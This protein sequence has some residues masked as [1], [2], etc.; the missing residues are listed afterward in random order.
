MKIL[1]ARIDGFRLLSGI[2]IDFSTDSKRNI[3][4]VRAAN[5]SGKT[6]MLTA[7]QWG[8]YGDD[9]LPAGYSLRRMDLPEG[10]SA[11]TRV[12]IEYEIGNRTGPQSY[13]LVR[14]MVTQGSIGERP[15]SNVDLYEVKPTGFE[16]ISS[17]NN[18][19]QQH[20]PA[21]LREVFFTDGDRALNFIEG[22]KSEQQQRVRRAIERMMGLSLLEVSID[23]VKQVEGK[24]RGRFN[25]LTGN[26]KTR[27]IKDQLDKIDVDLPELQ[28]ELDKRK[29]AVADLSAKRDRADRELQNALSAGNREEL[30]RDLRDTQKLRQNL[31][32]QL[33]STEIGQSKLFETE[34]LARHLMDK[35]F[36]T[37]GVTL[38]NLRKK[39][40]IPNK[41]V[42]ILEERLEHSDCICGES[43]DASTPGGKRRR[44]RIQSLIQDSQEADAL[45]AKVSDLYFQAR[46]L[47][48]GEPAS[49]K[50][51]YASAF[52]R[53]QDIS[54]L[55]GDVGKKEA[56]I[57]AKLK[58]IPDI[59][60]RQL[61][62][63][64]QIYGRDRDTARQGEIE[65]DKDIKDLKERRSKLESEFRKLSAVESKGRKV[66]REL[67]VATDIS[68]I[69][70]ESL[71]RMRTIEVQAVAA[72]MNEHF[73]S[74]IGADP[75]SSLITGAKIT[76]EFKIEVFGRNGLELDPSI[77]LNGASR[78]A[79]TISFVLALAEV[80]G[81][82]GP[83]VVDTPLGM[84]AGFV[85]NEVV[86]IACKNSSQLILFLTHDEIK[87]CEA[88]LDDRA[89]VAAT[90]TNPAHYPR[91]LKNDPGTREA[92]ILQCSCDHRSSC[93]VCDRHESSVQATGRNA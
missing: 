87:G 75:E 35:A 78:R 57:D 45:R 86:R 64:K 81:V 60:V 72:R 41:T 67:A 40:Q 84:M 49:W 20:M 55:I 88:I 22:R 19:I 90:L 92:I 63:M 79:L 33:K 36:T 27:T 82:E 54:S 5:E 69:I 9:A 48:N 51:E 76:P 31:E 7:L 73:L 56:E 18:H 43:L 10:D 52:K 11:N 30:A 50:K 61:R 91:I 53:R 28:S 37:A 26:V 6:T 59:N 32:V 46:T 1:N 2:E 38:D 23:H 58:K 13:L 42:P 71:D 77:D 80:S 66:A 34:L 3:T 62:E 65:L 85:K 25:E 21:E 4:V 39:G 16:E 14:R 12:E 74:M 68:N 70:K 44:E 83:N 47:F 8:F 29:D 15:A 24:L 89:V 17:P 93:K